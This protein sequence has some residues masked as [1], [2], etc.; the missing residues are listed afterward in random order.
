MA[1]LAAAASITRPVWNVTPLR[2][3]KVH[4][5]PSGEDVQE[6]ARAGMTFLVTAS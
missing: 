4:V 5:L 6:V 3:V 1:A 2:S